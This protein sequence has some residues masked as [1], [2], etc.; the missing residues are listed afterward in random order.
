[1]SATATIT[2]KFGN[3]QQATALA[4]TGVTGISVDIDKKILK[5]FQGSGATDDGLPNREFAMDGNTFTV[6]I[7]SGAITAV[8]VS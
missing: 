8:T 1:M 5:V 4:L 7:S 2:A 6:T 3:A